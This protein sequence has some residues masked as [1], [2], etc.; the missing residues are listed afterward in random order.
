MSNPIAP[1]VPCPPRPPFLLHPRRFSPTT[2]PPSPHSLRHQTRS[3]TLPSYNTGCPL[4]LLPARSMRAADASA[5][6]QAFTALANPAKAFP[7]PF[8]S[9]SCASSDWLVCPPPSPSLLSPAVHFAQSAIASD[10]F[11]H[12]HQSR[13]HLPFPSRFPVSH[14]PLHHPTT[15][16]LPSPTLQAHSTP[17]AILLPRLPGLHTYRPHASSAPPFPSVYTHPAPALPLSCHANL[18]SLNSAQSHSAPPPPSPLHLVPP[19][20]P[21][22]PP[23][24]LHACIFSFPDLSIALRSLRCP[25]FPAPPFT[26]LSPPRFTLP[27]SLRPTTSTFRPSPKYDAVDPCRAWNLSP[28]QHWVPAPLVC[29][30]SPAWVGRKDGLGTHPHAD[31]PSLPSLA[32]FLTSA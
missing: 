13:H 2:I 19:A 21:Y 27:L 3:Q 8:S 30:K 32:S 18:S 31:L 6:P 15:S 20:D 9:S 25:A 16:L 1:P 7:P 5:L 28:R 23:F 24:L 22:H 10:A 4:L 17:A 11:N 12:C 14:H 29:A 26:L